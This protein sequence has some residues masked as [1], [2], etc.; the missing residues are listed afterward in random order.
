MR[1][2]LSLIFTGALCIKICTIELCINNPPWILA[3]LRFDIAP[4][5]D[6]KDRNKAEQVHRATV[7]GTEDHRQFD[8][9]S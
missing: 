2:G 9:G 6:A 4:P 1:Y 5:V 3:Q 8:V 7:R